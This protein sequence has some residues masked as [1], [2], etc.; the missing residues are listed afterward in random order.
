[1][2]IGAF[3]MLVGALGVIRLPDLY[4]R[5]SAATKASTLGAGFC[6][7]SLATH[8]GELGITSRSL[9][10]IAFVI[11]TAPVA[12]HLISKVAYLS[13]VVLWK[14]TIADELQGRYDANTDTLT[15]GPAEADAQRGDV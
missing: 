4:M 7:L 11:I 1:M 15:S 14:G 12:A 2:M 5:V 6:L 13:G 8:F 10:T 3:F 9:A